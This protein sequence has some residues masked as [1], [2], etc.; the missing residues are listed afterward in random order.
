MEVLAAFLDH[1]ALPFH[2]FAAQGGRGLLVCVLLG[3]FSEDGFLEDGLLDSGFL[4][5]HGDTL[6]FLVDQVDVLFR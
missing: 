1:L 6:V 3:G 4:G 5:G 2:Q